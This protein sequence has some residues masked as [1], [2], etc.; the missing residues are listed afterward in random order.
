M[1][2]TAFT[3]RLDEWE[4]RELPVYRALPYVLLTLSVLV[5]CSRSI[6]RNASG[7]RSPCPRSPPPGCSVRDPS[8][9]DLP[10]A[11]RWCDL[12]HRL[13]GRSPAVLVARCPWFGFFAGSATCTRY[14]FLQ[15]RCASLACRH[16]GH[17][18]RLAGRRSAR[19]L[20][21]V[22][23]I[24]AHPSAA[25]RRIAG[26]DCASSRSS[27]AGSIEKRKQIIDRA[28]RGQPQARGDDGGER[29]PAR[30]AADPGARG[31]ML[32]ERQR[33]AREIHDTL[34][35]G[36][37]GII[38]Q[39]AG[40]R[41]G[42]RA[43]SPTGNG[44]STP[45]PRLARDSLTEARR[46]VHARPPGGA[47]GRPPAGG[48]RRCGRAVVGGQRRRGASV[49]TTGTARPLH[50]EVEVTLLRAAQEALANVAKHAARVAGRHH[51]VL[52][53]GRR[54]AGR[55]RRRRRVR[56]RQRGAPA[57]GT[58]G[59]FGLTGDAAAGP[60]AWP[61][62]WPSS[63][64]R[65]TAPRSPPASRPSRQGTSAGAGRAVDRRTEPAADS[66]GAER[67]SDP[68]C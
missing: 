58:G 51:P 52:H 19:A 67:Q 41:A 20:P 48:A 5:T 8:A 66:A 1:A 13:A 63:P 26:H 4:S 14:R 53:G 65:A 34:A 44:T 37:T 17:L 45:R 22:M 39:L 9:P 47:G 54:D 28:G 60:P 23:A 35:Q 31:G 50:P 57:A 21:A 7:S 61:A 36:L 64:S 46:S 68:G 59:G 33:M 32:D 12:L 2:V 11:A 6:P 15:G 43:T 49:T 29:R 56:P 30:T 25:E 27:A 24:Y 62:R 18:R 3:N 16:A 55:P 40:G 10:P 42:R 38:T